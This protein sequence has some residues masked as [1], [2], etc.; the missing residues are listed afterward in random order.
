MFLRN[1]KKKNAD[2]IAS[3]QEERLAP[4]EKKTAPVLS[5]EGLFDIAFENYRQ[6]HPESGMKRRDFRRN[7]WNSEAVSE[8]LSDSQY[9]KYLEY[10]G[11]LPLSE[12]GSNDPSPEREIAEE[13]LSNDSAEDALE[14]QED[15]LADGSLEDLL[16]TEGFAE[17]TVQAEEDAVSEL[18]PA[19]DDSFLDD[20]S[21]E[22]SGT[23]D[24]EILS[25]DE[26]AEPDAGTDFDSDEKNG[27]DFLA[28]EILGE[29][30][31]SEELIRTGDTES[32]GAFPING[33]ELIDGDAEED[34]CENVD[35]CADE[36]VPESDPQ[37]ETDGVMPD[38]ATPVGAEELPQEQALAE[39]GMAGVSS[40]YTGIF[41]QNGIME[42]LRR[43]MYLDEADNSQD[44]EIL[45]LS[46]K[47]IFEQLIRLEGCVRKVSVI[48][49]LAQL[50]FT[51]GTVED[52]GPLKKERLMEIIGNAAGAIGNMMHFNCEDEREW[53]QAIANHLGLTIREQ[54]IIPMQPLKREYVIRC[55]DKGGE[56]PIGDLIDT[57]CVSGDYTQICRAV[58]LYEQMHAVF[59]ACV[60]T[61]VLTC[62]GLDWQILSDDSDGLAATD[63]EIVNDEVYLV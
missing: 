53:N 5:E 41:S 42:K 43:S 24:A 40:V 1:Q 57:I 56:D 18:E 37:K 61:Q 44:D 51:Q 35:G 8:Y 62:A 15:L 26:T 10:A 52:D 50:V 32:D 28:G 34:N 59:P 19:F 33:A 38:E 49:D 31:D 30:A 58:F 13:I 25:T 2:A 48:S 63:I 36:L 27:D 7:V 21:E 11:E 16:E 12:E 60:I 45:S 9:R 47:E 29:P 4:P 6:A 20:L 55:Y 46:R 23:E 39:E 22:N 3:Q 54:N 14:D 17:E